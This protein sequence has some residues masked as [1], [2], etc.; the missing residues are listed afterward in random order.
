MR[1]GTKIHRYTEAEKAFIVDNYGKI[2]IEK[3]AE[4]IGVTAEKIHGYVWI[5][6]N[7]HGIN[8]DHAQRGPKFKAPGNGHQDRGGQAAT[9]DQVTTRR[10]VKAAF[11]DPEDKKDDYL[12]YTE[13]E[14]AEILGCTVPT[15]K[16]YMASGKL[17]C[18]LRIPRRELA[19]FVLAYTGEL[20]G[21]KLDI[22][23]II[24]LLRN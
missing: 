16:G 22:V 8:I 14:A 9:A 3:I 20:V 12:D 24:D 23:Q 19:N 7:K 11:R 17:S 10:K 6:R 15:I 13:D 18:R 1:N 2:P 21:R 5:L 4:K